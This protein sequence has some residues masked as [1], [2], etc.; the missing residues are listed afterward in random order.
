[1]KIASMTF[2]AILSSFTSNPSVRAFSSYS[3]IVWLKHDYPDFLARIL[4]RVS[5]IVTQDV[6]NICTE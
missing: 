2:V 3:S 4:L 1:M 6:E 5:V